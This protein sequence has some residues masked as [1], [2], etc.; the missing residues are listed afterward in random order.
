M[1]T[2][3]DTTTTTTTMMLFPQGMRCAEARAPGLSFHDGVQVDATVRSFTEHEL[4][5]VNGMRSIPYRFD[6]QAKT[7]SVIDLNRTLL[8]LK[9]KLVTADGFD[10]VGDHN[11]ALV[12]NPISALWKTVE[13]RLNEQLINVESSRHIVQKGTIEAWL[14]HREMDDRSVSL[15]LPGADTK[16]GSAP[17]PWRTMD[18]QA[19]N[20]VQFIGQPPVDLLKAREFLSP[21]NLL[22]LAFYP[23]DHDKLILN[24]DNPGYRIVIASMVLHIRQ[25]E[26]APKALSDLPQPDRDQKEVYHGRFGCIRDYQIPKSTLH[27]S[28][29]VIGGDGRLPKYVLLGMVDAVATG[30]AD[31]DGK[32]TKGPCYFEHFDLAKCSIRAGEKYFPVKAYTPLIIEGDG[33]NSC[34]REYYS[35]HDQLGLVHHYITRDHYVN[36]GGF[37]LPFNLT[38]DMRSCLTREPLLP[39]R[40]GPLTIDLVFGK[41]LEQTVNMFV[42]MLYDQTV[43]IEGSSGRAIEEQF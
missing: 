7:G 24:A 25:V 9:L 2:D 4:R 43:S 16:G 31:A 38:P 22:S 28:Q 29:P 11:V 1:P 13:V 41:E 39:P 33:A 37:L 8:E 32:K 19:G 18:F 15:A 42:Y 35:L 3:D 20:Q 12:G 40:Q 10:V 34:L 5:P 14:S 26:V 36:G 17:N 6:L 21:R 27:W 30:S 23:E